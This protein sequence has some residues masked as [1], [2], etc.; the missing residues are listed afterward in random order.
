MTIAGNIRR[1][2]VLLRNDP[3]WFDLLDGSALTAV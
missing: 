2:V 1:I 3:L